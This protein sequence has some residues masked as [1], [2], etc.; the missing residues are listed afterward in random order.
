MT[1]VMQGAEPFLFPGGDTGCLLTHGFTA[2]PQE[3]RGLGSFLNARGYTVLGVRLAGHGTSLDD[4]ACTRWM[5]WLCS[6][7]DGYALLERLCKSIVMVGMS[8][9]AVLNLLLSTQRM[10]LG[11][12]SMSTPIDLPPIP[13][14]RLLL[15]LLPALSLI[16][17]SYPKGSP[18]WFD[19]GAQRPR[20]AYGEYP[21]RAVYE[22]GRLVARIQEELPKVRSP[23]LLIHSSSDGFVPIRNVKWIIN[24]V[25][26]AHKETFIVERSN[27]II[28]CDAESQRVF[29]KAA[30]FSDNL[31]SASGTPKIRK[32][33]AA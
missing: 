4:M 15:P 1:Q 25:G 32:G 11:L 17:P 3:M 20:V 26:S 33:T 19:P 9:G 22:F 12:I 21:L 30:D 13:G 16:M 24:S 8:T 28:T 10:T 5:D 29:Q 31:A 23:I 14:L 27:H 6:V 7:E 18:N 2:S